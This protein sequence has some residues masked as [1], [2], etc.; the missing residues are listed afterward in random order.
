MLRSLPLTFALTSK[1]ARK[2]KGKSNYFSLYIV[3][4]TITPSLRE[5]S[6]R[7]FSFF[8]L[9][10]ATS[11]CRSTTQFNNNHRGSG[12]PNGCLR[13]NRGE[14]NRNTLPE[15]DQISPLPSSRGLGHGLFKPVTPVRIWLGAHNLKVVLRDQPGYLHYL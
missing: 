10:R 5:C 14:K 4:H 9:R 15:N 8:C 1:Q 6:G 11:L 13:V 3:L 7:V 12:C 2:I